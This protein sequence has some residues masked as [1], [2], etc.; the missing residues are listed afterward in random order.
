MSPP[1]NWL[2]QD[3]SGPLNGQHYSLR[4]D[5]STPAAQR[6]PDAKS[7]RNPLQTKGIS[8][9]T[10]DRCRTTA[11]PL[12]KQHACNTGR[13]GNHK[14]GGAPRTPANQRLV[15]S[16]DCSVGPGLPSLPAV[17][18]LRRTGP[19]VNA[20]GASAGPR[21]GASALAEAPPSRLGGRSDQSEGKVRFGNGGLTT[22]WPFPRSGGLTP[23]VHSLRNRY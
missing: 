18:L 7:S 23:A 9:S 10:S 14:P 21:A 11:G 17:V 22:V 1:I 20:I 13:D 5:Y 4:R 6:P 8:R 12:R 2:D 15:Q 16:R 3:H 19:P